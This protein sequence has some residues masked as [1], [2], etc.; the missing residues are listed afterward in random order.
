MIKACVAIGRGNVEL[1]STHWE[2]LVL[3]CYK[4]IEQQNG[5]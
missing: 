3:L 2:A 4:R 5:Q 1:V